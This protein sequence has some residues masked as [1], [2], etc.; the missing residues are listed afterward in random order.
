MIRYLKEQGFRRVTG[1]TS[2][3]ID[4]ALGDY[5]EI[6]ISA[7]ATFS[8]SNPVIN[9][10]YIFWIKNSGGS[11]IIITMG[12][13]GDYTQ[14]NQ[15]TLATLMALEIGVTYDGSKWIWNVGAAQSLL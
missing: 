1:L 14:A 7:G 5:F 11:S 10:Q 6:T 4:L 8:L 15:A 9:K 13:T 2:L 3:T 12:T